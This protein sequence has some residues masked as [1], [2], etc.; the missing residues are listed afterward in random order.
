MRNFTPQQHL[1]LSLS[2]FAGRMKRRQSGPQ[3]PPAESWLKVVLWDLLDPQRQTQTLHVS[4]N[5]HYAN[6]L[7][8]SWESSLEVRW[9]KAEW[10]RAMTSKRKKRW[11]NK[12]WPHKPKR[13]AYRPPPFMSEFQTQIILWW[14]M[15]EWRSCGC[16]GQTFKTTFMWSYDQQVLGVHV[17]DDSQL[18]PHQNEAQCRS[19]HGRRPSKS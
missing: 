3:P 17:G 14:R 8:P 10:S 18:L 9:E 15:T 19:T 16:F 4:C 5:P 1:S 2:A 11:G 12:K 7:T 6:E 13:N